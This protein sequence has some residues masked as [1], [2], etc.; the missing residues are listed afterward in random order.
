MT[1]RDRVRAF[2]GRPSTRQR[3][4]VAF[5][6]SDAQFDDLPL[7]REAAGARVEAQRH[8]SLMVSPTLGMI[9]N[10]DYQFRRL[11]SGAKFK[12]RD[13]TPMQQDRMLEIAWYIYE[14]NP[15]GRRCVKA[16]TDL[17]VGEGVGFEAEDP[18]LQEAGDKVWK[19][20]INRIGDRARELH[21][22]LSLNG[23]LILPVAVNDVSGVPTI[24]YIDP[25]QVDRIELRA[26]N[27]LVPESVVLK[28][29][30]G[31]IVGETIRIVQENPLT[32]LLEGECFYLG[33]NKL[34]NSSRGRSDYLPLADWLDLFDQ[35][36]FAEVERVRLLSA[37]VWDL[38]IKDANADL[39]KTRLA[40][41]GTPASGSV[42]G[43]NQN[44]KLE[45][46]A[47]SLNATDRSET[48][49]L[50]TIHIAGSLG[51]PITW[52]GWPDSTRATVEG[53]NDVAMKT[54]AARQKE[55]GAFMNLIMRF[56]IE[57]QRAANP[58]LFRNLTSEKFG[59]TM[60]EIQ[61]KDIARVGQALAQVI[62]GLD[63]AM[64]NRTVSRR[65]ASTITL[66]LTKHLGSGFDF[67]PTD[68]M[69]EADKDAAEN[70]A[71]Q[72]DAMAGAAAAVSALQAKGPGGRRNPPVANNA[73]ARGQQHEAEWI[74]PGA[75]L[76]EQVDRLE[77]ELKARPPVTVNAPV[78]VN[79]GAP[80]VE[81]T[82]YLPRQG[83]EVIQKTTLERDGQGELKSIVRHRPGGVPPLVETIEKNADGTITGT[84]EHERNEE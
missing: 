48:A 1:L 40:E 78:T 77:R 41:I 61:A 16:M 58:V 2:F 44:E 15:F 43:H 13:L 79:T 49:K 67:N 70:Q 46:Q 76:A 65:V 57:R 84:T 81:S 23:E 8:E 75:E 19:H 83:D 63:A 25:Y 71:K 30:P 47:P 32:G 7:R 37:F 55:F 24:G 68:V 51:M 10:D 3:E 39:I 14:Q 20:P 26:D 34:P 73:G 11:S 64:N 31:Q 52:F 62:S 66:A 9:D 17:V 82:V 21:D 12:R 5:M 38:E 54:P 4:A 22:A 74:G 33:V 18:K 59:I 42:F 45:P 27:V 50:L 72:D 36:M 35:Y 56:G 29:Q 28:R 53:Q 6:T 69:D 80:Q 60:P